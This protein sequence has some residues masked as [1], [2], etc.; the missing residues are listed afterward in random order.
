[1][2]T[3]KRLFQGEDLVETLAA[4]VHKEADLSGVPGEGSEKRLR[5]ITGMEFLLDTGLLSAA[6]SRSRSRFGKG[7]RIWR[8]DR[9]GDCVGAYRIQGR[10]RQTF[11]QDE[12]ATNVP[13]T[14]VVNWQNGLKK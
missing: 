13:L 10:K 7:G 5:D 14:V 11:P 12:A 6:P 3:G 9:R 2:L 4:V 8:G 1:M